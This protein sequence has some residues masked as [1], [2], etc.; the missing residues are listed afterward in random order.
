MRSFLIFE[1]TLPSLITSAFS[2]YGLEL[3]QTA[4]SL[5]LIVIGFLT[6]YVVPYA[7][8]FRDLPLFFLIFNLILC[9]IYLFFALLLNII[10]NI[11]FVWAIRHAIGT[12]LAWSPDSTIFRNV[13]PLWLP[14]KS[15]CFY[16]LISF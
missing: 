14:V 16:L 5:L 15:A 2:R 11:V 13:L 12:L 7:F 9:G 3:W 1:Q 10:Q 6:F 8:I 4:I